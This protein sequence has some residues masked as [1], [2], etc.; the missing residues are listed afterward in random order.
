MWRVSV[1]GNSGSGKTTLAGLIA[2]R[3]GVPH[4]ELDGVF[5]QP[6]WTQKPREE[7]RAEV[8]QLTAS[9]GWVV[10]GNYSTVSDIVWERADTVIWVD[11]PRARALYQV[12]ART[13]RRLVDRQ[14]LWN[15]NRE[16]LRD[17]FSRD[18][19]LKWA[20][21]THRKVRDRYGTAISDPRWEH[22]RFIRLCTSAEADYLL[23]RLEPAPAIPAD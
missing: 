16:R 18:S 23:S 11:T 8:D 5:H 19:I 9:G 1:V 12:T 17:T 20:W 3:L 15:G 13:F 2:D 7:F 4:V 22:L 14:E 21:D 6:G 10:D